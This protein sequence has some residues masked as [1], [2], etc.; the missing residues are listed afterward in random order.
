MAIVINIAHSLTEYLIRTNKE[1]SLKKVFEFTERL[2]RISAA[3][4]ISITMGRLKVSRSKKI[5][6]EMIHIVW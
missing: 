1:K 4:Y 6:K 3:H 2:M 5:K